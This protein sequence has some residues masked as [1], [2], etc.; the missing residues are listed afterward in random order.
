MW[1]LSSADWLPL[2]V[3][4]TDYWSRR[5]PVVTRTLCTSSAVHVLG[6]DENWSAPRNRPNNTNAPSPSPPL[7][8]HPPPPPPPPPHPHG[9]KEKEERCTGWRATRD[10]PK[11]LEAAKPPGIPILEE[12]DDETRQWRSCWCSATYWRYCSN[13]LSV[14]KKR[15][16]RKAYFSSSFSSP[17]RAHVQISHVLRLAES[18]GF[19]A[20]VWCVLK[21][22]L[23]MSCNYS[24]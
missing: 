2:F 18:V 7:P 21:L 13:L 1:R 12:T 14:V 9:K 16:G 24:L 5:V 10:S 3:G 19:V 6:N 23:S 4:T 22:L 8:P 17:S 15:M 20:V 11:E